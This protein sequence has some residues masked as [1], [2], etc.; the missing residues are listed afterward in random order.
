LERLSV[1]ECPQQ[2]V[3]K[4]VQTGP[5]L[6]WHNSDVMQHHMPGMCPLVQLFEAPCVPPAA[7]AKVTAKAQEVPKL[8]EAKDAAK[9]GEPSD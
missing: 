3:L 9:D 1:T 2:S 6:A 5:G 4:V 8:S 7:A